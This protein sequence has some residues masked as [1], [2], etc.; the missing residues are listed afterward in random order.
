TGKLALSALVFSAAI[1]ASWSASAFCRTATGGL[2][3][4]CTITADECCTT[5]LPLYWK[6]ACVGYD[7]QQDASKQVSYDDAAQAIALAFTKWTGAT[8]STPGASGSGQS[9]ASIDV[10]DLGPVECNQVQYNKDGPN[11]HV[12]I[13]DDNTWPHN[14]SNNTLALTTVT[15]DSTSGEIYDADMEINTAQQTLT[16][17]DPIPADGYDLQSIV[18]HETGHFLGMAHSGDTRATMYAHYRQGAT[19]MRDLTQDDVSGIC[20]IYPPD[21]TRSIGDGGTLAEDSC[22]PTPRH[23]F[24]SSCATPKSGCSISRAPGFDS[25]FGSAALVGLGLVALAFLRRRQ[26]PS[27]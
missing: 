3:D 27:E 2:V 15:F 9:R 21:G 20:S 17:K 12:I 25:R 6:N 18:T 8:C 26:L 10:R 13:F 19:A 1:F 11:Q 22:D 5:G 4:G 14:D 23:G 16:A 7:I 24:G